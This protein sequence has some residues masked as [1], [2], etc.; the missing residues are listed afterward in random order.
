MNYNKYGNH[1]CELDGYKF[2]SKKEMERYAQLKLEV[3]NGDIKDLELQPRFTL[4]EAGTNHMGKKYRK[5]EYVADFKYYDVKEQLWCVE[6]V[7]G[8]KTDVYK[9]KVKLFWSMFPHYYF[10]E[11]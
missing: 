8:M 11:L 9:I 3:K 2:D 6:D 10:Q 1:K 7:K 4:L 5:I